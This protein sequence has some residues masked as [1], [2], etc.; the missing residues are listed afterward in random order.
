MSDVLC[1]LKDDSCPRYEQ[2]ILDVSCAYKNESCP[3]CERV[4]S[5]T[6]TSFVT[7]VMHLNASCHT[8]EWVLAHI[9]MSHVKGA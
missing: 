5:D 6:R 2:F 8:Y 7:R 9:S 3:T 1:A 4:M